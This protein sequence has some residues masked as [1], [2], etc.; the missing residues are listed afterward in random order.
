MLEW[1]E[2]VLRALKEDLGSGDVTTRITVNPEKRARAELLAKENLV[3]AGLDVARRAFALV[4]PETVFISSFTDGDEISKGTV[5]A[6]VEGRAVSLLEA[7]RV[8]LN[9]LQR[10]CG[11]ATLTRRFVAEVAGTKASITDTRKTTPGLRSMEKYAVRV[12]GGRNHRFSLADGVLIK[13]N[14]SRA[15]GGIGEAVRRARAGAPH[16]LKIEVEVSTLEEVAEA[17]AARADILLLD[18]M[19]VQ[20]V[21]ESVALVNGRALLEVSGGMA[22]DTVR[23]FAQTGVDIL[24]VGALTH[25]A[26]AMDI[27]M[28]FESGAS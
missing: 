21:R 13:E 11:I 4:D 16:P 14:H 7:E 15:A 10:L 24:S 9:F 3:L 6:R 26:R 25:S 22:L 8:A 23:T 17:V 28:L 1:D 27:S 19:D 12:G 2:T 18:N 20:R 5:F